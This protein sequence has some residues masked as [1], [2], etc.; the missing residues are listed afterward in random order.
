MAK[1]YKLISKELDNYKA[2]LDEIERYTWI[3]VYGC[4]YRLE[5]ERNPVKWAENLICEM[6]EDAEETTDEI[7]AS[8]AE[9]V[10]EAL[11]LWREYDYAYG[12]YY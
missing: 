6:E 5:H 11:N 1:I 2:T 9:E 4:A 3:G 8:T 7:I 10:V 12:A